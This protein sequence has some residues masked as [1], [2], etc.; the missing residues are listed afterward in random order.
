[1]NHIFYAIYHKKKKRY[2]RGRNRGRMFYFQ[3]ED[4]NP[5]TW[6]SKYKTVKGA[7]HDLARALEHRLCEFNL[8]DFEIHKYKVERQGR[9][10]LL[11][12]K[13]EENLFNNTLTV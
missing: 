8:Q 6:C 12:K 5:F 10:P 13:E 7:I 9:L 3:L 4:Y 1:M 11:V 2:V